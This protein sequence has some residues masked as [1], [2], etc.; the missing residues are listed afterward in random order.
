MCRHFSEARNGDLGQRCRAVSFRTRGMATADART[1]C[2]FL[3]RACQ[4][5]IR[6]AILYCLPVLC[7]DDSMMEQCL[8]RSILERHGDF[9]LCFAVHGQDALAVM[10]DLVPDLVITDLFMPEWVASTSGK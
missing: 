3:L 7:V 4:R 5:L 10:E 1:A 2:F 8:A 9:D 6:K